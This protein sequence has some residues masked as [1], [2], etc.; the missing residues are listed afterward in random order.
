MLRSTNV[1]DHTDEEIHNGRKVQLDAMRIEVK[2]LCGCVLLSI[3]ASGLLLVV[4]CCVANTQ[5]RHAVISAAAR[6]P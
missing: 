2:V 1:A 5:R 6:A 4:P 3:L